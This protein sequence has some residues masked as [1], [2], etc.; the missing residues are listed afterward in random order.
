[1]PAWL[2][3]AAF[4]QSYVLLPIVHADQPLGILLA[5]WATKR[6]I[7]LPPEQV[8]LLRDFLALVA[9]KHTQP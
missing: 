3:S 9:R 6:K 7:I 8:Q 1:M 5:G 2:R 4:L